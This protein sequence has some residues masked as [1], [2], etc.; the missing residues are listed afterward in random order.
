[1]LDKQPVS[2][3]PVPSLYDQYAGEL[4]GGKARLYTFKLASLLF[5]ASERPSIAAEVRRIVSP[6]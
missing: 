5:F 3:H 6:H 2:Y 1:M 4:S